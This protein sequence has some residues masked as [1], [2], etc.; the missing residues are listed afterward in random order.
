[1]GTNHPVMEG[2]KY[3]DGGTVAYSRRMICVKF[4]FRM[5]VMETEQQRI[6]TTVG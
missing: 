3:R 6:W 2:Y 4:Q 5:I 1:M